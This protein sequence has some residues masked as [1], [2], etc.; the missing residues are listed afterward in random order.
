MKRGLQIKRIRIIFE[1]SISHTF[2]LGLRRLRACEIR[3]IREHFLCQLQGQ[4]AGF[5]CV[6]MGMQ[7]FCTSKE[8]LEDNTNQT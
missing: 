8:Y 2:T 1:V 3:G 6:S 5:P 7:S 4:F